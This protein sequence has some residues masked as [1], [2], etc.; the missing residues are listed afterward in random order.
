[1]GVENDSYSRST[2]YNCCFMDWTGTLGVQSYNFMATLMI[3][4]KL[5]T[6]RWTLT[7][8]WCNIVTRMYL[9]GEVSVSEKCIAPHMSRIGVEL[10]QTQLCQK[11][12]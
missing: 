3:C 8:E 10:H 4:N 11:D 1:M 9:N 6:G 5:Q 2:L 12:L 7:Y